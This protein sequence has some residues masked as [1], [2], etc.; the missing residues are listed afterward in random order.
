MTQKKQHHIKTHTAQQKRIHRTHDNE[1]KYLS[2][3]VIAC[4]F[5]V[6]PIETKCN[7]TLDIHIHPK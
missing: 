2:D 5:N 7:Q 1:H 4:H 6:D 3:T